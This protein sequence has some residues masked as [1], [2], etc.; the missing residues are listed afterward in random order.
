VEVTF[1]EVQTPT[2]QSLHDQIV[3][4]K[5]MF[6]LRYDINTGVSSGDSGA[7]IFY[8]GGSKQLLLGLHK[9]TEKDEGHHSVISIHAIVHAIAGEALNYV[10]HRQDK[11]IHGLS[12]QSFQFCMQAGGHYSDSN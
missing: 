10:L 8:K 3:A 11:L 7:G 2:Q 4:Y 6:L 9:S 12:S 1:H 5:R